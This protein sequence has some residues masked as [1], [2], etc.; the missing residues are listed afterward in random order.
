MFG[1]RH[2]QDEQVPTDPLDKPVLFFSPDDP[3]T[4][5]DSFEGLHIF[6]GIGSGKTSGSGAF[7]A[8]AYL[9]AGYGGLVLTAKPDETD[10]W[11]NYAK[12]TGR[13]DDLMIFGPD[14]ELR[15][16][17]LEYEAENSREGSGITENIV[18]LFGTLG[19]I[20]SRTSGQKSGGENETYWRNQ[21]HLMA[22]NAI[23]ALRLA[24]LEISFAN[25]QNLVTSAPSDLDMLNESVWQEESFCFEALDLMG[26]RKQSKQIPAK[27]M[28]SYDRCWDYWSRVYPKM[29]ERPRSSTQG[30]F[31]G[32]C[33]RFTRGVLHELFSTDTN[34][35]PEDS[36]EGKIIVL[37]LPQKQFNEVGVLAQIL[38]KYCWQRAIER[39]R[40][41]QEAKP[42]FLWS[43]EA[44]HF[45][46]EHDVGFQAT[47]RSSRVATV[48]LTQN[49]PNYLFGLG[50]D[51][52]AKALVDSLLGNLVTKIFHN[53]TCVETNLYAARLFGHHWINAHSYRLDMNKGHS[54]PSYG[55]N[56]QEDSRF[57]V[58]P[59]E[60]T[61]LKTGGPNNAFMVEGIV[62]KGGKTFNT[63]GGNALIVQF[64]QKPQ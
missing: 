5:R 11:I 59:R 9:T 58:E 47:S 10:L 56:Y 32:L 16:N 6:G 62:H 53:N 20:D 40:V 33:D 44:Q 19:Q 34:L 39:R 49:I 54:D 28:T 21:L 51:I 45:I 31:I 55:L 50:G 26:L 15:F 7:F 38:F 52:R 48:L 29:D 24:D 4:I 8:R 17:A 46:N 25:L 60:F 12:E 37:D 35:T 57:I 63:S 27:E 13:F 43:D 3:F 2:K 61:D 42:V 64:N 1:H 36:L 41:N 14:R 23:D 30:S 22:R 18:Q